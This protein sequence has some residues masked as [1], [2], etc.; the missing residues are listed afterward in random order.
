[1]LSQSHSVNASIES[2]TTYFLRYEKLWSQSHG[3]NVP[4]DLVHMVELQLRS[5]FVT[6]NGFSVRV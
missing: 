3:V 4:F 1:M 6:T 2:G 5:I